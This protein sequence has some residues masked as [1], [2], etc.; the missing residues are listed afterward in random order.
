[1]MD[2]F[3][4]NEK[5][6]SKFYLLINFHCCFFVFVFISVVLDSFLTLL[7]IYGGAFEPILRDW[8]WGHQRVHKDQPT[9]SL[10]HSAL[11]PFHGLALMSFSPRLHCLHNWL[12][13]MQHIS[14]SMVFVAV[15]NLLFLLPPSTPSHPPRSLPPF[16]ELLF[17]L[18]VSITIALFCLESMSS[19]CLNY[20]ISLAKNL[21]SN[22]K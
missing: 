6:S 13:T 18:F 14:G 19:I 2:F 15:N 3:F 11:F 10:S 1:M 5:E 20:F 12:L 22:F 21:H 4:P 16:S 17:Y 7:I 9:L 8:V